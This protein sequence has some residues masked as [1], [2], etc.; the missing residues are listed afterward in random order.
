MT[1]VD[2]WLSYNKGM[3]EINL[4]QGGGELA[5]GGQTHHKTMTTTGK[6]Y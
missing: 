2:L 4:M 6:I 3:N 5:Q 1:P